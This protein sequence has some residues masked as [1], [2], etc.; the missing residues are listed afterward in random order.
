MRHLL[1]IVILSGWL[2]LGVFSCGGRIDSDTIDLQGLWQVRLDPDN[3]GIEEHWYGTNFPL[4]INLP[5]TTDEAGL[6]QATE[7]SDYGQLT[8]V[9]KYIGPA[10]YRKR[11]RIPRRW[12][13]KEINLFLERVLWESRVWLDGKLVSIE[14][15]LATPHNH[16][17]GPIAPG[18]HELV[19]RIN[20]EMIHNIGDKGH[21]YGEAMQTIWNGVV[22]R[23]ELQ[24]RDKLHVSHMRTFP[25]PGKK[26]LGLEININNPELESGKLTIE[27][28]HNSTANVIKK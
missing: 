15:H 21:A 13:R 24:A 9:V 6:G 5:G 28:N 25:D 10:W 27:I 12:R 23:L 20:N 18:S 26:E 22:G 1:I 11:I 8:R 3:R 14:D 4:K 16:Q 7:V 19:V 17:L 2:A